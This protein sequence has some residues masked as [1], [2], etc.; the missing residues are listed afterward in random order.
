LN[1]AL[2]EELTSAPTALDEGAPSVLVYFMRN[3]QIPRLAAQL[4]ELESRWAGDG[5]AGAALSPAELLSL[6][7]DEVEG[8]R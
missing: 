5:H 1:Q 3:R 2:V 4:G 8:R 7:R 6:L